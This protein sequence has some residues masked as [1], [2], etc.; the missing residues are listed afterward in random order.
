MRM[1]KFQKKIL[2]NFVL[3]TG[4]AKVYKLFPPILKF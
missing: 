4:L 2:K 1:K 3:I